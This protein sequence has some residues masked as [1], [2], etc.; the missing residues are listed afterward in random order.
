[1]QKKKKEED[2]YVNCSVMYNY[3]DTEA[4]QVPLSRWV[5]KAT[6]GHLPSGILVGHKKENFT[7]C[8]SMDGSGEHY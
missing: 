1:M 5:D 3:Q 7:L 6:M 8:N 2:P 4:A